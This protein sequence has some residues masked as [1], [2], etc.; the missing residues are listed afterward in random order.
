MS[1]FSEFVY[2]IGIGI[3]WVSRAIFE[4]ER[5]RSAR[6]REVERVKKNAREA[7]LTR[8]TCTS[9][10]DICCLWKGRKWG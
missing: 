5:M 9:N 7:S 8:L 10:V 1:G 3:Y 2:A 4:K 6:D